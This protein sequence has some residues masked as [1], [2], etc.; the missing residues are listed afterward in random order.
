MFPVGDT[1]KAQIRQ[2]AATRGLLVADKPDSHDL[3]FVADGTLLATCA[4][5]SAF[6]PEP[7]VDAGWHAARQPRRRLCVHGR[8][9]QG[10]CPER[11]RR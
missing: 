5:G 6:V 8:S 1:T 9:A 2:E 11:C 10:A 4:A 7:I 3:C